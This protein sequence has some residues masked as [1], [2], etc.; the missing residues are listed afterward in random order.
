MA[1]KT[2]TE[3]GTSAGKTKTGQVRRG[4]AENRGGID[5]DYYKRDPVYSRA[6]KAL[7]IT[8]IDSVNDLNRIADYLAG[9]GGTGP[10]DQQSGG[11]GG[12]GF[13][14]G[15][16]GDQQRAA[17]AAT[18]AAQNRQVLGPNQAFSLDT[19]NNGGVGLP[20][21]ERLQQQG[22]T[23]QQIAD[24]AAAQNAQLGAAAQQA[25][26]GFTPQG[27][28]GQGLLMGS[29]GGFNVDVNSSGGVGLA[30]IE[31]LRAQGRSDAEI[32]TALAS[33]GGQVGDKAKAALFGTGDTGGTEALLNEILMQS[34][35]SQQAMQ[36]AIQQQVA[37]QQQAFQQAQAMMQEQLAQQ[38]A[39]FQQQSAMMQQQLQEQQARLAEQQRKQENLA[40]A[41]VPAPEE[42]AVSAALG[43]QR[44][45][46]G[47][48]GLSDLMLSTNAM[49]SALG[50]LVMA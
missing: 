1:W 3:Y 26:S 33:Y 14:P 11:G 2:K 40:E 37:Q 27:L 34:Q 47:G 23:L 7:G 41:Y 48:T 17:V 43:D 4:M 8:N 18:Q 44:R 5:F 35:G 20:D 22:Y 29:S 31:R 10:A 21:I 9:L 45:G 36:Q 28:P 6:A 15:D 39:A 30:D 24:Q 50:G 16:I 46:R 38:Q 32:R 42:S 12:D 19:N 25:L 49:T 13:A